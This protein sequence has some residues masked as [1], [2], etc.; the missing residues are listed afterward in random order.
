MNFVA[1]VES[2]AERAVQPVRLADVA[3]V[4]AGGGGRGQHDGPSG[5]D[6]HEQGGVE[7]RE[8]SHPK[9]PRG[10]VSDVIFFSYVD[11]A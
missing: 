1:A 4:K 5:E 3:G 2:Q 10:E 7:V 11:W 9:R 8:V 6:A